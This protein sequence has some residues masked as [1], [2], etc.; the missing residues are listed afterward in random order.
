MNKKQVIV[1]AVVVLAISA[2]CLWAIY[3]TFQWFQALNA[4]VAASLITASLGLIGLWYAQWQSKTRDIAESHRTNKIE[5][6]NVFFDLVEKFQTNNITDLSEENIPE[7][8]KSDFQKLNRGLLLWASPGVI[9]AYLKFRT[10]SASGGDILHAVDNMY[11]E[12]RKDLGNSNFQ[13]KAGDLIRI[14]LKDPNEL[15]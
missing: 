12:I 2:F 4:S 15:K 3:S 9:T 13:L 5:V 7:P 14:G 11:R 10:V 6:Y 8:L 1:G